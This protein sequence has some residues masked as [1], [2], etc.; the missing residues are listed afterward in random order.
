ML[1]FILLFTSVLFIQPLGAQISISGKVLDPL[2][3]ESLAYVNI[4]IKGKNLGTT[5]LSDG[6]FSISIPSSFQNDTLTFSLIGY[7]DFKLPIEASGKKVI[8]LFRQASVLP[9]ISISTS[10]LVEAK[11]G[12]TKHAAIHF[13]DASINQN[14]IF[15]IAQL[16]KLPAT[17]TK[18]NSVDL[19]INEDNADSV[20]FRIN[21]YKF[22]GNRPAERLNTQ[23]IFKTALLKEGWLHCIISEY[24]LYGKNEV[25]VAFEF[26]PSQ[27]RK[28]AIALEVKLGGRSKSFVRKTSL[29][30][31]MVPPH[32]YLM[33][34][35]ALTPETNRN[36][37]KDEKEI[38]ATKVLIS[39]YVKDTFSLFVHLPSNYQKNKTKTYPLVL[40][41][42][43]N[44]YFTGVSDFWDPENKEHLSEAILIGI[45]YA[46]VAL[47]DSLRQRD[48]TFPRDLVA[49][50]CLLC[51]GADKFRDFIQ[52]ELLPYAHQSFRTN[53]KEV[54]IMG[55]SLGGYFP[56][57]SLLTDLKEENTL[58]K[59]YV[60][61]S[62]SLNYADNYILNYTNT[63][64]PS[65]ITSLQKR[66]YLSFGEFDD[67]LT[68]HIGVFTDF[69]K[70]LALLRVRSRFE[71]YPGLQHMETPLI[72]FERGLNFILSDN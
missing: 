26:L 14:D 63:L 16:I 67:D 33:N 32:H 3:R 71:I 27:K 51:G 40:L 55:H 41:L 50:S 25:V 59:N 57:W 30:E 38:S 65:K 8:P 34:L 19:Y 69:E 66:C 22:D 43:A 6:T 31:W 60:C 58:I 47:M 10:K 42:D 20:K 46:N 1:R 24:N 4:G 13:I 2:S 54:S 21:I 29:G 18:L 64:N 56:I 35:T 23:P 11:F 45:G 49:D 15:E 17:N 53:K 70:K 12:L 44:A 36:S 52:K 48:Y 9:E 5:S 62:P 39:T 28:K 68:T 37:D 72:G 61:I 7:A